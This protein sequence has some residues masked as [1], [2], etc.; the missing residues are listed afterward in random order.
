[1]FVLKHP[2]LSDMDVDDPYFD[3]DKI[4]RL[5]IN[6][7][8]TYD[9]KKAARLLGTD[10]DTLR[11]AL[12]AGVIRRG[13]FESADA[14]RGDRLKRFVDELE[15]VEL[16]VREVDTDRDDDV[17][18]APAVRPAPSGVRKGA[19]ATKTKPVR[20]VVSAEPPDDDTADVVIADCPNCGHPLAITG[21]VLSARCPSCHVKLAISEPLAADDDSA[22]EDQDEDAESPSP[23]ERKVTPAMRNPRSKKSQGFLGIF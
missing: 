13:A 3:P 19:P 6:P 1:M 2:K 16:E 21:D 12:D 5:R 14:I 7:S 4:K 22:D 20:A 23:R 11:Q 9:V 18:A 15:P 8:E 10:E 17:H